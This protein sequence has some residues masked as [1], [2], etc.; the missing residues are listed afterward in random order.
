[1]SISRAICRRSPARDERRRAHAVA[2]SHV[3]DGAA[4]HRD[5]AVVIEGTDD[6]RARCARRRAGG[7]CR[8]R[9]VA[10]GRVARARIHR[11]PGQ[12]RRRRAVQRC[13]DAGGN[14]GDRGRAP[15]VRHHRAAAD[16]DQRHARKIAPGASP[17]S[18]PRLPTCRACSASISRGRFCRRNR[19][20]VHD[21]RALRRPDADDLQDDRRRGHGVTL[22]TL[23]P[24]QVPAG[25]HRRACRRRRA[26]CARPFRGNLCADPR[27][28]GAKA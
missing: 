8:V 19:P 3:F 7:H 15:Q 18:A 9:T 4:L 10:G 27:R 25:L 14:R 11:H 22:V 2:A 26:R 17:R 23:A 13:A 12:R 16:A 28:D 21:P 24:E 1:M 20:G 5:S 6:R